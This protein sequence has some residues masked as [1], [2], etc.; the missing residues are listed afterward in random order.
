M[1]ASLKVLS[2]ALPSVFRHDLIRTSFCDTNPGSMKIAAHLD[3][4]SHCRTAS[5]T[6]WSMRCTHQAFI[7][8][9]RHG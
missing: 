6:D 4:I 3:H 5:G 2:Y 9:T 7:I 1:C 8:N